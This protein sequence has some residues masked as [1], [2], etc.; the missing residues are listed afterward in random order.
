P[1]VNNVAT[2]V[3]ES[4]ATDQACRCHEFSE[5]EDTGRQHS[6]PG[7]T[8]PDDSKRTPGEPS[9]CAGERPVAASRHS[10]GM[11]LTHLPC[12][13]HTA[14]PLPRAGHGSKGGAR[15]GESPRAG[16]R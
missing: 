12:S 8:V 16:E 10:S 1:S 2:S 13:P 9:T 15:W 3:G 4:G 7:L 11:A 14:A 6:A 5:S